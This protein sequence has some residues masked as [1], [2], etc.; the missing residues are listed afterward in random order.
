MQDICPVIIFI[1]FC[2]FGAADFCLEVV[3]AQ[4][5][6]Y[7]MYVDIYHKYKP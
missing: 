6:V 2:S 7:R 4:S 5:Y 3:E 1:M